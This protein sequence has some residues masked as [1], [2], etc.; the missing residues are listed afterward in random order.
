MSG[1]IDCGLVYVLIGA[2]VVF[3]GTN[4]IEKM[5][6]P[7]VIG[8]IV[9]IIGLNLAPATV[10]SVAKTQLD[11]VMALF[12]IVSIGTV[13]VFTSGLIQ[14]LLL[15]IGLI[16]SF[17]VYVLLANGLG[18]GIPVDFSRVSQAA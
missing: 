3:A 7:V 8:A 15:L 9:M 17:A 2:I 10:S 4:W 14:R 1:I 12:T 13:A 6:P 18:Y 16:A 5:M 11:M